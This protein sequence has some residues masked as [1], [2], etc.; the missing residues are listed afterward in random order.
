MK[1]STMKFVGAAVLAPWLLLA[2]DAVL[3]AGAADEINKAVTT[4]RPATAKS[5]VQA[6]ID[7]YCK[8]AGITIG[9]KKGKDAFYLQGIERVSENV[10]SPNFVRARTIAYAKAYQRAVASYV[11]DK[12]GQAAVEQFDTY[13]S[14]QSS[15]RLQPAADVK[16]TVARIAEKTAQLAE[17]KLD[18]GLRALGVTPAGTVAQKRKLACDALVKRSMQDAVGASAGLLPVQ[19]FE[20][21]NEDGQYAIGVV[22]RGGLD[23]ETIAECLKNKQ[24]PLLTRPAAGLTIEEAL[25][26]EEELVS[27]FGVRLFFDKNGVPALLSFGQWGSAYTG[28]DP[29]MAEDAMDHALAQAET[30][31]DDQLTLFINSTISVKRESERGE[32]K[33]VDVVFDANNL[34]TE[35]AVKTFIDRISRTSKMTGADTMIGRSTVF[36]KVVPHPNGH[37][38]A[39]CVRLWSFD[40]Y[41]AMKRVIERPAAAQP[42]PAVAPASVSKGTSGKRRG[43]SYDF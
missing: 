12:F 9:A 20:G 42:A 21:W 6:D 41:D 24:R 32:Q 27:Q 10:R 38:L 22:V 25:P 1:R 13:F 31:A 11:M 14:D 5:L 34:P 18:E 8:D 23:T 19:T 26:T 39:I 2:Q 28:T 15:D 3:P 4:H 40:K 17:A 33:D 36:K 37:K 7:A 35:Q 29:D 16:S 43:R 30:E